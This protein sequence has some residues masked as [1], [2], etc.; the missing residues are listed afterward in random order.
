MRDD[1]PSARWIIADLNGSMFGVE[2]DQLK[3]GQTYYVR[4]FAENSTGL[5]LWIGPQN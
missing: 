4:G 3:K 2:I 1:D 5:L